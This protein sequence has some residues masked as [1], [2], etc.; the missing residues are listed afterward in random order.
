MRTVPRFLT[1]IFMAA[2]M[3]FASA[4]R[5]QTYQ[6]ILEPGSTITPSYFANPIGPTEPLSG[7]FSWTFVGYDA[8]WST[9]NFNTTALNFI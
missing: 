8:Y 6:Y 7:T 2:V 4:V 5:A 1:F 3:C 9:V